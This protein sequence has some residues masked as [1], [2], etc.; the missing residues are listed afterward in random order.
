M[1]CPTCGATLTLATECAWCA[2]RARDASSALVAG[3]VDELPERGMVSLAPL[4]PAG[5]LTRAPASG[6]AL[7]VIAREGLTAQLWRQPAV[8]AVARAGA[9][10]LAFSVGLRLARALLA[11]ALVRLPPA[12]RLP[13][14]RGGEVVETWIYVRQQ[15]VGR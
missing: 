8:R 13:A 7:T 11:R 9:G 4:E 6:R 1:N 15:R 2:A 3:V 10:A 5:V 12:T 14:A